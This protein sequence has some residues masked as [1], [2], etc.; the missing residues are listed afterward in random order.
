MTTPVIYIF[1]NRPDVTR[2]TFAVIRAQ[3]PRQLYLIADGPRP[4]RPAES[5]RCRETR[6]IVESMIDWECEVTRDYSEI[7]L[8][9]GRRLSSGLTTAFALLGEAIV[10]EDDILPHADFFPFCAAQLALH[11]ENPLIH[12]ICGF[13]PLNRYQP[14]RGPAVASLQNSIWGW[15]SWHR[16]WADYRFDL[17]A[18]QDPLVEAAIR[19][20][21]ADDLTFSFYRHG[22]DE[23][24][25]GR[26]DTWDFQWSLAMLQQRRHVVMSTVNF[27]E[28]I[29]FDGDATHTL[30]RPAWFAG[31]RTGRAI[32]A[33]QQHDLSAPDRRH[34]R[35]YNF[36]TLSGASTRIVAARLAARSAFL[37]RLLAP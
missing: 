3:R 36:V 13:N 17:S 35:L 30:R 11:R 6:G 16:K 21:V 26:L 27:V 18:W 8:G 9:C 15:A 34:D 25:S 4:D 5:D 2:R 37:T 19:A 29:G 32:S 14:R 1:F 12:A 24:A 31:L 7:N 22:F 10:L 28:N 20:Y 33:P 23:T